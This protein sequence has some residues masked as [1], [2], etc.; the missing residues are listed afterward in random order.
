MRNTTTPALG[1][2]PSELQRSE[3]RSLQGRPI[4]AKARTVVS[5]GRAAKPDAALL[6]SRCAAS[7]MLAVLSRI[8][9]L[10]SRLSRLRRAPR[11]ATLGFDGTGTSTSEA[12][13]CY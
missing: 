5:M 13:A 4:A 6:T 9:S 3:R 11:P 1:S 8:K 7:Q 2:P 12:S 10:Q